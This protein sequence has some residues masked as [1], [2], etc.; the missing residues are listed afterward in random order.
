MLKFRGSFSSPNV[1]TGAWNSTDASGIYNVFHF[2]F[3]TPTGA[4]TNPPLLDISIDPS[5]ST[6]IPATATP[7]R[8]FHLRVTER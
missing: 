6:T 7:A 3:D 1:I 5:G 2:L 4:F 8:F